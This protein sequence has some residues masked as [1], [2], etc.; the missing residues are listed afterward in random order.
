MMFDRIFA[1]MKGS[2]CFRDTSDSH[3][4][5]ARPHPLNL[6]FASCLRV[7][8]LGA[9]MDVAKEGSG[10]TE[11]AVSMFVPWLFSLLGWSGLFSE[12]SISG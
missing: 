8:V 6:K 7:I 5:G 12:T 10:I 11:G 4:R 1:D 9:G 2:G 3:I